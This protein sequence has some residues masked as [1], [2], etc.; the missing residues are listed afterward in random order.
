MTSND[1]VLF[2]GVGDEHG[3]MSNF[4][5][6]PIIIDGVRFSCNEQ[7]IVFVVSI[8]HKSIGVLVSQNLNNSL[9]D[10]RRLPDLEECF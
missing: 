2:Y 7:Y 9:A 4:A 8:H 5:K 6:Y 3:Y 10:F 1:I